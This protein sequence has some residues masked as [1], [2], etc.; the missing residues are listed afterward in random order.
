MSQF[1]EDPFRGDVHH[2]AEDPPQNNHNDLNQK[3][4]LTLKGMV[5]TII[6]DNFPRLT[7]SQRVLF[8]ASPFGKFLGMHIPHGGPLLV[9]FMMLHEV[10]SQQ[11]FETGRFL[12]EIER[13][14]LD[15]GEN[16]YIL[17]CGLK[18]GPY[19]DLLHDEKGRSN[20]NLRARLFPDISDALLWLKD[21][22]YYIMSLNYLSLQ[23]EDAVIRDVK[24]GILTTVYKLA[25]DIDDWNRL[26]KQA[27]PESKKVHK[28]TVASFM[29]LFKTFLEATQFYIRMPTE[30]PH[31]RSWRSMTNWNSYDNWNSKWMSVNKKLQIQK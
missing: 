27:N 14:Q 19:V 17:I 1:W 28:Y 21:L 25:D 30:L 18:V 20:S 16:E 9:H 23:D 15:F 2:S 13:M 5:G 29:L 10:M 7:Q 22:E 6:K 24:T 4:D 11:M 3:E 26:F 8:E 31:M 12:F